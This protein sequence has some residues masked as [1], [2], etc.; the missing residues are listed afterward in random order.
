MDQSVF[1][2]QPMS[3]IDVHRGIVRTPDSD[4][5]VSVSDAANETFLAS[6]FSES[7]LSVPDSFWLDDIWREREVSLAIA[8]RSALFSNAL[9]AQMQRELDGHDD[10]SAVVL[11]LDI[12]INIIEQ[13]IERMM[14][15]RTAHWSLEHT[16]MAPRHQV[17]RLVEHHTGEDYYNR[18]SDQ[19]F[20]W[21]VLRLLAGMNDRIEWTRPALGTRVRGALLAIRRRNR[22]QMDPEGQA[23]I[24]GG[25]LRGATQKVIADAGY[26]IISPPSLVRPY[27]VFRK[28]KLRRRLAGLI[29][30]NLRELAMALDVPTDGLGA[31]SAFWSDAVPT[32]RIET[33][34]ENRAAYA[35]WFNRNSVSGFITETGMQYLDPNIFFISECH[36]RGVPSVVIQH[37]GQYGY[38]VQ[39]PLFYVRDLG[40]TS[41]FASWGWSRMPARYDRSV[42]RARIVPVPNPQLSQLRMAGRALR[43]PRRDGKPTLLVP[44]SKS[45]TLDPRIGGNATDGNLRVM[46]RFVTDVL[47]RIGHR[48]GKIIITHRMGDFESDP[49]SAWLKTPEGRTLAA[50]EVLRSQDAP[51]SKLYPAVDMVLWDTTA[52]GLLES[53][54]F[55]VPTVALFQPDRW[56]G[57]AAP[58]RDMLLACGIGCCDPVGAATAIEGFLDDSDRWSAARARVQP[59]LDTYALARD[60]YAEC[61]RHFLTDTFGQ[62]QTNGAAA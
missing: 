54:H 58:D 14:R 20:Q 29:E 39:I 2:G 12:A 17:Y 23:I 42:Q 38:D 49:I 36:R 44:V 25:Q 57:D 21:C 27:S 31:A 40:I 45:R 55:N 24:H 43:P 50:V 16:T 46:R 37:G 62:P 35:S 56:A 33:R 52:T 10:P 30:A 51:A 13:S 1:V 5:I 61:W 8:P 48:F 41:L 6:F 3:G 22:R 26:R 9:S 32:T 34:A 53:L 28:T 18:H 60:D 59:F 15:L 11:T 47:A 4:G 7:L 19:P